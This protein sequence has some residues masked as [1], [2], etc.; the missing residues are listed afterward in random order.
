MLLSILFLWSSF[1][2]YDVKCK[3][4]V[5]KNQKKKF[6]NC[7]RRLFSVLSEN[8]HLKEIEKGVFFANC[9]FMSLCLKKHER[10]RLK[11]LFNKNSNFPSFIILSWNHIGALCRI[12]RFYDMK[13]FQNDHVS[14]WGLTRPTS[15]ILSSHFF[16]V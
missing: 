9:Q 10:V 16:F 7:L 14:L 5:W 4:F 11:T 1:R 13:M 8:D 2:G 3:N 12:S 15:S 6:A